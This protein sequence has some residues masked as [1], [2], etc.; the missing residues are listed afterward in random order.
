[1]ASNDIF[2]EIKLKDADFLQLLGSA[3]MIMGNILKMLAKWGLNSPNW[4]L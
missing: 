4:R 3:N 1:M 2:A